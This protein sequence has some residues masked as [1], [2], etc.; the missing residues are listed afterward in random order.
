VI[1][2]QIAKIKLNLKVSPKNVR[3]TSIMFYQ[4]CLTKELIVLLLQILAKLKIIIL[5]HIW[6]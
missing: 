5:L 3:Q 2:V 1:T 4:S 6:F